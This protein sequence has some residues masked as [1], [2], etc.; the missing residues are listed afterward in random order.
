M[1]DPLDPVRA[2][3][4]RLADSTEPPC[5]YAAWIDAYREAIHDISVHVYPEADQ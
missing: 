4:D 1:S 5:N 2:I 3:L